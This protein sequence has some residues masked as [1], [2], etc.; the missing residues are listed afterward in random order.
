ME[1]GKEA[2]E[3]GWKEMGKMN[4]ELLEKLKGLRMS[5]T[6]LDRQEVQN[7]IRPVWNTWMER[8]GPDGKNLI[9]RVVEIK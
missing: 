8:V 2:S 4:A 5:V 3:Y 6:T 7:A 9:Q 1:A